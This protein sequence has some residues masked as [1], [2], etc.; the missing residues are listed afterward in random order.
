MRQTA[1]M[2]LDNLD[3]QVLDVEPSLHDS[4]SLVVVDAALAHVP[5]GDGVTALPER[6]GSH[7]VNP[8]AI[9]DSG[10]GRIL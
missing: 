7:P 8:G 10:I 3:W 6:L 5:V 9:L 4:F 2:A 1:H